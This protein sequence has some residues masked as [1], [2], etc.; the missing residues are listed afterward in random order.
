MEEEE[1][2]GVGE[3][4]SRVRGCSAASQQSGNSC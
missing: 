2:E 1:G 3:R 4:R